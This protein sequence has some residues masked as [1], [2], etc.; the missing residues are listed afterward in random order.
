MESLEQKKDYK[1]I[2]YVL[3]Y[4]VLGSVVLVIRGVPFP[5]GLIIGAIRLKRLCKKEQKLNWRV[6]TI[7]LVV[8]ALLAILQI[9]SLFHI[10][11]IVPITLNW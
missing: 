7:A 1:V 5:L 6:R 11:L 2:I 3:G 10:S 9:L 4:Y 8:G